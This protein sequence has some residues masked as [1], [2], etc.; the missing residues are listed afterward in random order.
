MFL[1]ATTCWLLL[2]SLAD[3]DVKALTGR[4]SNDNKLQDTVIFSGSF[5]RFLRF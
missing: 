3:E 2:L 4:Y 1:P 5:E